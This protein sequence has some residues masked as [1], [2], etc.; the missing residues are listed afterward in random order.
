VRKSTAHADLVPAM[1]AAL[2]DEVFLYPSG[3]RLLLRD[4]RFLREWH[5]DPRLQLLTE[6]ERQVIA[7]AAEG[8]TSVEIGKRLFLSPKTVD[9]YRSR[10]M[11]KLGLGN[12]AE[13]IRF[14]VTTRLLT[15]D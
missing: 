1:E 11:H 9:S 3:N 13:L 10:A 5:E 15:D 12:R 4:F 7:L 2:R 6:H 14:A 8:F